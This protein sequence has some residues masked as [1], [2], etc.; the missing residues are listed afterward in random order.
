MAS[1]FP[2]QPDKIVPD[3][4]HGTDGPS[5]DAILVS[6]FRHS[7][8]EKQYLGDGVYFFEAAPD[9]AARWAK[10]RCK[11]IRSNRYAVL[12]A[13]VQL[14]R[15]LD[16]HDD[17]IRELLSRI[18]AK[19]EKRGRPLSDAAV[20]SFAAQIYPIDTVRAS[21]TVS[22]GGTLFASSHFARAVE[23]IICVRSTG[24][25]FKVALAATGR[26]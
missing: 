25:I 12:R 17:R 22:S 3:A 15:C 24:N 20:I 11:R 9:R 2:N 10:K 14:G 26:L 5:A 7:V 1:D 21:R 18:A 19:M 13:E 8:G 23:L 16:L 4:Y 6:G